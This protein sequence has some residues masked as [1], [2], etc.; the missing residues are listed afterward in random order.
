MILSLSAEEILTD[1][2]RTAYPSEETSSPTASK[3]STAGETASPSA[4]TVTQ[5]STERF[6]TPHWTDCKADRDVLSYHSLFYILVCFRSRGCHRTFCRKLL[7]PSK[8]RVSWSGYALSRLV[9]SKVQSQCLDLTQCQVLHKYY[10]PPSNFGVPCT[11]QSI[12]TYTTTMIPLR[13][14]MSQKSPEL[15]P[16]PPSR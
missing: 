7:S 9:S 15:L 14:P 1:A 5:A 8:E 13:L 12:V 6:S 11:H 2:P 4:L 3:A 10:S 16:S